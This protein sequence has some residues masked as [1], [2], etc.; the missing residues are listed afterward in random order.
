MDAYPSW[1]GHLD[2]EASI[3]S[4]MPLPSIWG[5]RLLEI[6]AYLYA[7]YRILERQNLCL[8]AYLHGHWDH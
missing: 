1:L 7:D 2:R 6:P 3:A 4:Q 5:Q 8:S